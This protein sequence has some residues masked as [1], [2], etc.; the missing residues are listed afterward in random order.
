MNLSHSTLIALLLFGLMSTSIGADPPEK[1]EGDLKPLITLYQA[2][3]IAD[4]KALHEQLKEDRKLNPTAALYAKIL[5]SNLEQKPNLGAPKDIPETKS[6]AILSDC[7]WE[8]AEIGY[9]SIRRNTL[10]P[11]QGVTPFFQSAAGFHRNG[12]FAHAD[13]VYEF[14]LGGKWERLKGIG[15]LPSHLSPYSS[16]DFII[17]ADG[18]KLLSR[19]RAHSNAKPIEIDLNVRGVKT[20]K[21]I[22]TNA[23]DGITGDTA[24]WLDLVLTRPSRRR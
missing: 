20:L 12:L 17:E 13:S 4:F 19:R 18:K 7:V 15:T 14:D 8:K 16:V 11:R 1:V 6:S 23:G 2:N 3:K 22:T 24:Y 5:V 10:A 9:A 21:F